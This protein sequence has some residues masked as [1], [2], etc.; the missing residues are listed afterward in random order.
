MWRS[1]VA[2]GFHLWR[3]APGGNL[4]DGIPSRFSV[5]S[6]FAVSMR[7][8]IADAGAPGAV[9]E[10]FGGS[11]LGYAC[12][13]CLVAD[14]SCIQILYL[15]PIETDVNSKQVKTSCSSQLE[16]MH[17]EN[18]SGTRV[19]RGMLNCCSCTDA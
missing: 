2:V 14:P 17:E 8:A 18:P 12:E 10:I 19:H 13:L 11:G 3:D 16:T 5:V 15:F 6:S 4:A 9:V 7:S 1:I